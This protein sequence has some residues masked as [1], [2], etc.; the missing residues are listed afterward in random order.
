MGCGLRKE[1]EGM[2]KFIPGN[3]KLECSKRRLDLFEYR[4]INYASTNYWR[5]LVIGEGCTK[6][7]ALEDL[8]YR[9]RSGGAFMDFPVPAM[10]REEL[11]VKLELLDATA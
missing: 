9:W 11:K 10:N 5:Y 3:W 1:V 4:V 8:L 7:Y 6:A 2:L